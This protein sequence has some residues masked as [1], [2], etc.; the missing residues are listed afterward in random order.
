MSIT[1]TKKQNASQIIDDMNDNIGTLISLANN[2][3]STAF[4]VS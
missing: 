1:H 2:F 4:R 3:K